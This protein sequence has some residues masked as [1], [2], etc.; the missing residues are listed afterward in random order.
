MTEAAGE[1]QGNEAKGGEARHDGFSGAAGRSRAQSTTI[2]CAGCGTWFGGQWWS[3]LDATVDG[4]R[5]DRL[6]EQGFAGINRNHC[7]S[8]SASYVVQEPLVVHRPQHGQ[9]L[10]VVP[11]RR[12][13]RAQHARAALIAAVADDPGQVAPAYAR[14]PLLVAGISG[15]RGLIGEVTRV[16]ARPAAV[17]PEG[18]LSSPA[19]G[20]TADDISTSPGARVPADEVPATAPGHVLD[21]GSGNATAEVEP[22]SEGPAGP[23]AADVAPAPAAEP[24]G[25]LAALMADDEP[26]PAEDRTGPWHDAWSLEAGAEP[27]VEHE[28]TRVSRMVAPRARL[29]E[30]RSTRLVLD[31]DDVIALFRVPGAADADAHLTDESRLRFQLH[32]TPQGPALCLTLV[33]PDAASSVCWPLDPVADDRVLDRLQRRFVVAVEAVDGEGALVGR[34]VFDPPLARNVALARQRVQRVGG[35]PVEARAFVASDGFDRLGQLRHNFDEHAFAACRSASEAQLAL[36]IVGFW[37]EPEREGYLI[38]VQSFPRVWFEAIVR[39]V[40]SAALDFGLLPPAHLEQRA[41]ES[42]LATDARSL[43]SRALGAFAELNLSTSI[44]ANDLDPIDNYENWERLLTRA[45]ALGLAVDA[46]LRGLALS[47]MEAARRA[48]EALDVSEEPI[49]LDPDEDVIE[50]ESVDEVFEASVDEVTEPLTDLIDSALIGLLADPARRVSAAAV[51]VQRSGSE[52]GAAL[53]DALTRMSADDLMRVLPLGLPR[54]ETLAPSLAAAQRSADPVVRRAV[55]LFLAEGRRP[56]AILALVDQLLDARDAGWVPLAQALAGYGADV[57]HLVAGM[58]L[59]GEGLERVARVLASMPP[60]LR[61]S[62]YDAGARHSG[63]VQRC[64]ERAGRLAEAEPTVGDFVHRLETAL[65]MLAAGDTRGQT[66]GLSSGG[67]D[68]P[69]LG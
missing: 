48:A 67:D 61:D 62:V 23:P 17:A 37:S 21:E 68:D 44:K 12:M 32:V 50:L 35:S 60:A 10:L 26:V 43:L 39:R 64:L 5:L 46:G 25:L 33:P 36:S 66:P 40:L 1:A 29:P 38:D 42:G 20:S 8:C 19:D 30:G 14:E 55:T 41:I 34:R 65:S 15:L 22:L 45:E 27:A 31:D 7:P 53:V 13:H 63:P 56:E 59:D 69:R 16:S 11:N 6:L 51:L 28:P 47:A 57:R 52:H 58:P 9:L 49:E 3:A 4:E 2:W 24:S 18:P 54:V